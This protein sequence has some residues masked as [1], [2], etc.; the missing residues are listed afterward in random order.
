MALK[1]SNL[2]TPDMAATVNRIAPGFPSGWGRMV[3]DPRG[4]QGSRVDPE[5]V[6]VGR[7]SSFF[8]MARYRE[9]A[10]LKSAIHSCHCRVVQSP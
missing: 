3:R 7:V 4:S 10:L 1:R 5:P 2:K 9:A 8:V 6:H